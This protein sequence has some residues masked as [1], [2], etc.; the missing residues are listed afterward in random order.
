M[1]D[2]FIVNEERNLYLLKHDALKVLRI[3]KFPVY[4]NGMVHF[5]DVYKRIVK[6]LL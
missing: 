1:R 4:E 2:R 6:T 5:K 3:V